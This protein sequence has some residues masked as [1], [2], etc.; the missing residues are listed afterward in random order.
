MLFFHFPH[1]R[2][3]YLFE[4]IGNNRNIFIEYFDPELFDDILRYY[5]HFD[6]ELKD[7]ECFNIIL[8]K[9]NFSQ[10]LIL[11]ILNAIL[12]QLKNKRTEELYSIKPYLICFD[13]LDELNIEYLTGVIWENILDAS[14]R[15]SSILTNS[16]LLNFV[17]NF[18][19][20][21]V[22]NF[23][24]TDKIRFLLV[25][26]EANFAVGAAQANDRLSHITAQMHFFYTNNGLEIAKK[27]LKIYEEYG[28]SDESPL[29][30]DDKN[31]YD[32]IEIILE[33]KV[34]MNER[35][36]P[37][38]NYDHRQFFDAVI[39]IT[40]PQS[41]S[42]K[43]YSLFNMTK[44]QY[45]AFPKDK[46][47]RNGRRGILMNAFIRHL[48]TANFLERIAPRTD[49]IDETGHCNCVRMFLTVLCNLSFGTKTEAQRNERAEAEPEQ[50][51]L[52]E[53]YKRCKEIMTTDDFFDTITYLIDFDKSSWAHLITVYNKVPTRYGNKYTFD[54]SSQK[55]N[56]K[57]NISTGDLKNI[58]ISA[59]ASAY[60]FLR[61]M[62]THFEYIAAYKTY[63]N[64]DS[65][66]DYKPL[67][68]QTNI[69]SY[70][71]LKWKFEKTVET[72][73]KLV[74][75]YL[76]RTEK[77]FNEVFR[78]SLGYTRETYCSPDSVYIF[79]GD[80]HSRI[81]NRLYYPLYMTRLLTTHIRYLDDFRR[82]IND[83]YGTEIEKTLDKID[84]MNSTLAANFKN[85]AG[86]NSFM[87]E[88]IE[89]YIE[90]LEKIE[91]P[92]K[93]NIANKLKAQLETVK[94]N[95]A[96]PVAVEELADSDNEEFEFPEGEI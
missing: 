49:T 13:N 59:N 69:G 85:K 75:K 90:L 15:L 25:F 26:R 5:Q 12:P 95:P 94:L 62:F 71:T 79:K 27:R 36:I 20:D 89:K 86:I 73:Y 91:D 70:Q 17:F 38:F 35:L 57:N 19:T 29:Y 50:V 87:L 43:T 81:R 80:Y 82:Y 14:A 88:Y 52:I 8:E 65:I 33:D 30:S 44:E 1:N 64:K 78:D 56:L 58:S 21:T 34:L 42:K 60:I 3:Q 92:A 39:S 28:H 72:V 6:N 47:M 32:L 93:G 76:E 10:K 46:S 45:D 4:V 96:L 77:F 22:N 16:I 23:N 63:S 55:E 40:N 68:M 74:E 53:I 66:Y 11:Y 7:R 51:S 84:K 2:K 54:F 9:A 61:Y 31:I 41:I 18:N 37:L 67:F 83:Y 24:Y 48:S